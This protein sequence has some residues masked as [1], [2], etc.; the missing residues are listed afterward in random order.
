MFE[1]KNFN[2]VLSHFNCKMY[3]IFSPELSFVASFFYAE[4]IYGYS[5]HLQLAYVAAFFL[6]GL[7]AQHH[8]QRVMRLIGS[9]VMLNLPSLKN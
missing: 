7:T 2:R 1:N 8:V 4:L 6:G 9:H 5:F 3:S